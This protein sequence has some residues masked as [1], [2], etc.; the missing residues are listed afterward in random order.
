V[1]SAADVAPPPN[2][3]P[4]QTPVQIP[5]LQEEFEN[6]AEEEEEVALRRKQDWYNS[7]IRTGQMRLITS[8]AEEAELDA[9]DEEWVPPS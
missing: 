8:D 3:K 7:M 2:P 4:K 6:I 9:A 5:S 1:Y